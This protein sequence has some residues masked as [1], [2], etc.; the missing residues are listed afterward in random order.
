MMMVLLPASDAEPMLEPAAVSKL[1]RL[2]VTSVVLLG[3]DGT[4]ALVVEGWAFEPS[5]SA[6]A[7]VAAFAGD[8]S[9]AQTLHPIA[10]MAVSAAPSQWSESR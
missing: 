8:R 5:R 10:E 1:T 4:L 6:Q 7:V 2:G 9:S 3:A